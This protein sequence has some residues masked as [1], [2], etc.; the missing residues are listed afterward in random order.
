MADEY[1]T[2]DG[3]GVGV[4]PLEQRDALSIG[5]L[6]AGGALTLGAGAVATVVFTDAATEMQV[7]DALEHM[8]LALIKHFSAT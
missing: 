2:V 1:S 7:M 4:T 5:N 3:A 6:D 8:K